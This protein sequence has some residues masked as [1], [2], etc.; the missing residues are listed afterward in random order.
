MSVGPRLP[1]PWATQSRWAGRG[2]PVTVTVAG[3]PV[4]AR[5]TLQAMM[6]LWGTSEVLARHEAM[7]K[8]LSV[9]EYTWPP[10]TTT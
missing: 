1:V 5:T 2:S 8:E 4:D 6:E 3:L 10:C 9:A 7:S